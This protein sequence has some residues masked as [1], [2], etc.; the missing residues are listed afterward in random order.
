MPWHNCDCS[1]P[2]TNST[3]T[4]K[5]SCWNHQF[6][7]V[8][9]IGFVNTCFL[10]RVAHVREFGLDGTRSSKSWETFEERIQNHSLEFLFLYIYI[11]LYIYLYIYLFILYINIIYIYLYIIYKYIIYYYIL[12]YIIIYYIL[13]YILLY[14]LIYIYSYINIYSYIY[15]YICVCVCVCSICP[16]WWFDIHVNNEKITAVKLISIISVITS[17]CVIRAPEIY[18]QCIYIIWYSINYSQSC[19]T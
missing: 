4:I 13:L 3:L 19:C 8:K 1:L 18:S 6:L 10:E 14:I 7:K 9:G 12:L 16:V 2:S 11:F 17:V 5:L 15:I